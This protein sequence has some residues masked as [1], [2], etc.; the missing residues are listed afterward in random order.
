MGDY[1]HARL[2]D[3]VEPS[4]WR[5]VVED[6][7][8]LLERCRELEKENYALKSGGRWRGGRS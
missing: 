8:R 4:A 7:E 3:L 6:N 5:A 1:L 2:A